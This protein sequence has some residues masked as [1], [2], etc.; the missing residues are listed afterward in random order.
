MDTNIIQNSKENGIISSLQY[1]DYVFSKYITE[2]LENLQKGEGSY[3][4]NIFI[5]LM[6]CSIEEIKKGLGHAYKE[7]GNLLK[8]NYKNIFDATIQK[9]YSYLQILYNLQNLFNVKKI[10]YEEPIN[11]FNKLIINVQCNVQFMQSFIHYLNQNKYEYI[12]NDINYTF[13]KIK[14]EQ[15]IN[16][17][18]VET[19]NIDEIWY[20]IKI[21]I[22]DIEISVKNDIKMCFSKN[23][24]TNLLKNYEI[25]AKE[26]DN[27][28]DKKFYDNAENFYDLIEDKNIKIFI[29]E[30][31]QIWIPKNKEVY[32]TDVINKLNNSSGNQNN[33][34]LITSFCML[35]KITGQING[36]IKIGLY[37]DS[38]EFLI[39]STILK[40]MPKLKII[41]SF[42]QICL[43][44]YICKFI[45][46]YEDRE[47]LN[48]FGIIKYFR[49]GTI[50]QLL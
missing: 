20:N 8:D 40:N 30:K 2:V 46:N 43:Y 26:N 9:F 19:S 50:K 10:K 34:F 49:I 6:V 12:T 11:S 42:E 36:N 18:D 29:K 1:G 38:L 15:I 28:Y 27:I 16:I 4:N 3:F 48:I 32:L 25:S 5:F 7:I 45:L 24:S 35:Y 31:S 41:E 37:V 39:L 23:N 22:N 47:I 44:I 33:D 21:C 17:N 13:H 14:N